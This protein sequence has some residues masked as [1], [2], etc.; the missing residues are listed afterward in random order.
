[1]SDVINQN[2]SFDSN[3][4]SKNNDL[5]LETP[6]CLPNYLSMASRLG[7]YIIPGKKKNS[8]KSSALT[9]LFGENYSNS[10]GNKINMREDIKY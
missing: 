10:N 1:V 6:H 8:Y 5:L 2:N 7:S 3:S 9:I 4:Y